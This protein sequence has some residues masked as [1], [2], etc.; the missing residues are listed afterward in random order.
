MRVVLMGG[1]GKP[2]GSTLFAVPADKVVIC[3]RNPT[4]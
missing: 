1:S 2:A 4:V 3:S